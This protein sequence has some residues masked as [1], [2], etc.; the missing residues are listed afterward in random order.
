MDSAHRERQ[1]ITGSPDGAEHQGLQV[2]L[3]RAQLLSVRFAHDIYTRAVSGKHWISTDGVD[4][5]IGPGERVKLSAG[6]ALIDGEGVLQL[7]PAEQCS[8]QP[9]SWRLAQLFKRRTAALEIDIN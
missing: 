4:F 9:R 6:L 5:S 7:A 3:A 8:P 1:T 2:S